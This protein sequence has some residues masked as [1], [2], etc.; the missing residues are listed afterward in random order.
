MVYYDE[1]TEQLKISLEIICASEKVTSKILQKNLLKFFCLV[2]INYRQGKKLSIS[3]HASRKIRKEI[4]ILKKSLR[5]DSPNR[6]FLSICSSLLDELD[7]CQKISLTGY[8]NLLL[9]ASSIL[10]QRR[11]F[12]NLSEL[13]LFPH[14]IHIET[15]AICN[16]KCS[17]CD[18]ELL[19]R[20]GIIM[21]D[22]TINKIFN[23]LSR[24]PKEHQFTIQP[25]KI[26][27]PFLEKRLPKIIEKSLAFHP[28]SFVSIISNGSY[29]PDESIHKIFALLQQSDPLNRDSLYADRFS[30]T[31][32]LNESNPLEYKKL[33]RLN[34]EI[35]LKN[36]EKIHNNYEYINKPFRIT[37]SR[38]STSAQGDQDFLRFCKE[39]FPLFSPGLAKMNDW[40]GSNLF[41][42]KK[43]ESQNS[44]NQSISIQPCRRWFDLSITATGEIALCCMDSGMESYGLGNVKDDDCL[45]LY[46]KKC[47][48]FIPSSQ[49]RKD[50]PNP[51]KSCNYFQGNDLEESLQK[52]SQ[53]IK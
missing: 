44:P 1:N 30:I 7:N 18:Y 26:S 34:Q 31:F 17:F 23:D 9:A 51:C 40:S 8:Q 5:A 21:D 25:Y 50:S 22:E 38:V 33:M 27:E 11:H 43:L 2:G 24:I 4:S 15:Q 29:I 48:Q 46:Q 19:K 52:L 42:S 10:R 6:E 12:A 3:L 53:I 36:L 37:L 14:I 49:Q 39:K 32:S 35:T 45:K 41:S 16:A 13:K 28:S 20:K 47:N